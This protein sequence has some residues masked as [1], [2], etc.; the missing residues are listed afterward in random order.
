MK[1]D[2]DLWVLGT[3]GAILLAAGGAVLRSAFSTTKT[4]GRPT[5]PRPGVPEAG[6]G[7]KTDSTTL[8][9]L[10]ILRE[11]LDAVR[12]AHDAQ[13]AEMVEQRQRAERQVQ[14]AQAEIQRLTEELETEKARGEKS[15]GLGSDLENRLAP[16]GDPSASREGEVSELQKQLK[17]AADE[18][19]AAR[20]KAEA[21]E[22][23]IEGVRA[24]SR[25]LADEL[26]TLK[27]E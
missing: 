3:L 6:G 27:G 21:L 7:A 8:A 12:T 20:A 26:R 4:R 16:G 23:L 5:A 14:G 9:E 11:Q 13:R 24:R 15:D 18:R 25:Q 19:D 17:S 10:A 1:I 22:R 2:A